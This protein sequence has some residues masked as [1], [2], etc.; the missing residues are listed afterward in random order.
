SLNA[1]GIGVLISASINLLY[2]LTRKQLQREV[3]Q[4]EKSTAR[5]AG[6]ADEGVE[7]LVH[8]R[9]QRI[10]TDISTL[11]TLLDFVLA[12]LVGRF[13]DAFGRTPTM[14]LAVG[15]SAVMRLSVA[16]LPSLRLYIFYRVVVAIT[17]NAWFG[18]SA[19]SISDVFGRGSAA[20]AE[21]TSRVQRYALLAMLTGTYAGRFV[22]EPQQAFAAVGF[23]QLLAAGCVGL[24]VTETLP[25]K[26]KMDWSLNTVSPL[27]SFSFFRKSKALTALAVLCTAMELPSHINIDAVYRRQKFGE[28]WSNEQDSSQLVVY[29]ISGVLSTLFRAQLIAKLGQQG[30]GHL[31]IF[32]W[33]WR[34]PEVQVAVFMRNLTVRPSWKDTVSEL[35]RKVSQKLGLTEGKACKL[36]DPQGTCLPDDWLA[37]ELHDAVLTGV[38]VRVARFRLSPPDDFGSLCVEGF[39]DMSA[40]YME[41]KN[42]GQMAMN[43]DQQDGRAELEDAFSDGDL[44]VQLLVSMPAS[45]GYAHFIYVRRGS[46]VATVEANKEDLYSVTLDSQNMTVEVG[47]GADRKTCVKLPKGECPLRL[48]VYVYKAGEVAL[49]D[50]SNCAERHSLEE[51]EPAS[52]PVPACPPKLESQTPC[53]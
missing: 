47:Q 13:M 34:G 45:S 48:G 28:R 36:L 30:N 19:A 11:S 35:R 24:C 41:I 17:A 27:T 39:G 5:G 26:G 20:F 40:K 31:R 53:Q 37:E 43:R 51:S 16:T 21:A 10:S 22:K 25:S 14:L 18:A 49:K 3:A 7:G 4:K 2:Q 12:P 8:Q 6:S 9:V 32:D 38:L 52:S 1:A 23:M 42:G 15:S 46:N 29:Q 44:P 50:T 33:E